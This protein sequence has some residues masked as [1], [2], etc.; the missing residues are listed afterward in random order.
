LKKQDP[1]KTTQQHIKELTPKMSEFIKQYG[2]IK[3]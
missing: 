3:M 2:N 1:D